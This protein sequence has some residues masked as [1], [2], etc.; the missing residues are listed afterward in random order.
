MIV[1]FKSL[2]RG[3]RDVYRHSSDEHKFSEEE[4]QEILSYKNISESFEYNDW[5]GDSTFIKA[6]L[7][8]V[9]KDKYDGLLYT[10]KLNKS[11]PSHYA[12]TPSQI[13]KNKGLLFP[14]SVSCQ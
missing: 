1:Q 10:I 9:E 3:V 5:F 4:I 13:L 7:I 11:I 6:T 2:A 12:P 8:G 14:V